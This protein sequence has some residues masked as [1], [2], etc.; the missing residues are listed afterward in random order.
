MHV[1][2]TDGPGPTTLEIP[3][4]NGSTLT[5]GFA[6]AIKVAI[7]PIEIDDNPPPL[8]ATWAGATAYA[9]ENGD[10]PSIS[11]NGPQHTKPDVQSAG[12]L[13]AD[14]RTFANFH[15]RQFNLVKVDGKW[16]FAAPKPV[17]EVILS[18]GRFV[19]FVVA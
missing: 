2:E 3:Q 7:S 14:N 17:T 6:K 11:R 8:Y 10:T 5:V 19:G 13:P 12:P 18:N 16:Q 15:A 1:S 9:Y 4:Q